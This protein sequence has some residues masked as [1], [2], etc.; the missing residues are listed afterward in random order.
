MKLS[1]VVQP[2]EFEGKINSA[3]AYVYY[4]DVKRESKLTR[5][6]VYR[7]SVYFEGLSFHTTASQSSFDPYPFTPENFRAFSEFVERMVLFAQT[8]IGQ[9]WPGDKTVYRGE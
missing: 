5:I 8:L 4:K 1:Y 9:P 7:D 2:H 3:T 6:V